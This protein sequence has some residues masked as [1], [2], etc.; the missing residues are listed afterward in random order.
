M[1]KSNQSNISNDK[2]RTVQDIIRAIKEKSANGTYIFRGEPEHYG[3]VSSNLWRELD[4]VKVKYSEI[5]D[6]QSE[7]IADAKEYAEDKTDGFEI[8]T[9][10][11]HYG[12]K[13][14]LIDFTT[15]YNV[16]FFFACY[17]SPSEDGRIIILQ[18]TEEIKGML[19]YPQKPEKRVRAQKSVFVEPPKGYIEQEYKLV[20]IPKDLKLQILQHLRGVHKIFPKTV[21]NDLHGFIRSQKDYWMAYR[22]FYNG[23]ASEDK[24]G[25]AKTLKEK[26][27]AYKEAIKHYTNALECE[28]QLHEVYNNRGII[29]CNIDEVDKAI[30]NFNKAIELNPDHAIAYNNRG[31]AYTGKREVDKAIEDFNRAIE[32]QSDYAEAYNNRGKAYGEKADFDRAI[33]NYNKA[34]ELNPDFAEPYNNRGAVYR[35]QDDFDRAFKNFDKAIEL[36]PNYANAYNNRG[37]AYKNKGNF[38]YALKDLNTAI[39]L[40]PDFAIAYSHRGIVYNI[41]GEHDRAMLDLN[42]AI[43]LDPQLAEAYNNRGI[44]YDQQGGFDHAIEDYNMAIQL[45]PDFAQAYN[46]RGITYGKK[47]EANLALEDF[48]EAIQLKSDYAIAYNNRGAIYRSKGDYERAIEDCNKAIEFKNDYAESYSNRGAAYRNKGLVDRAIEDYNAAVKLNPDFVEGYFN[49]GIAYYEKHEFDRAIED[50]TKAIDLNPDLAPAYCNRGNAYNEKGQYNHAIEDHTKAIDLNPNLASAYY[51]RGE[52]WLQLEEWEKAKADLMAAKS[53]GMDIIAAFH[54]TYRNAASFERRYDFKL[55]EDIAALMLQDSRNRYPRMEEVLDTDGNTSES[56]DVLNLVNKLRDAGTPLGEYL[57]VSPYFGIK[58]APTKV[59]VVD[60]T[61]RDALIA[62]HP[63]SADVLKPFLRG[64]DI[65]RWQV[66]PQDQWLIFTG[67][68]IEIDTY[69]A[70]QEY[71]KK[72]WELLSNR[73]GKGKWYELHAAPVETE[74]FAKPKLVCPNLYNAQTFAIETEGLYCGYTC[75]IIPTEETWLCGLLNTR[76]VEWF[77]SQT[78]KQLGS[79]E[80]QAR[81]GYIKQIPIP[82]V[83]ATQKDLVRKFVDYLIYLQKQPTTSSKDLEPV[84]KVI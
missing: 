33:A 56:P 5:E 51:N 15:D 69:P 55:P 37:I 40:N 7:I 81:S 39:E 76:I 11:Q 12:G 78:S 18:K 68:G 83:N 34:I 59:F 70:I 44:A 63:S 30:E 43:E 73:K 20:C 23:L 32:L 79:G 50:Y 14:N 29:Y 67:R 75:C 13:T 48:S 72:Y 71:L 41:K 25:E 28:L 16:A 45:K 21:Y 64:Q 10:I 26:Q 9:D 74:R 35:D 3:K 38:E 52:V 77:Y 4:A 17:G 82:D 49:R 84:L 58:T 57:K 31:N 65:R 53:M 66:E 60:R 36:N 27:E 8:L 46:N 42:G 80:L 62:A 2:P 54:N 61:T 19:R 24:A 1:K 6:I 47:G 22:D